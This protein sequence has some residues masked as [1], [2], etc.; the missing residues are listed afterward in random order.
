MASVKFSI[1]SNK[2]T[3]HLPNY[4]TKI[5]KNWNQIPLIDFVSTFLSDIKINGS[6][7]SALQLLNQNLNQIDK[8]LDL[9]KKCN[10]RGELNQLI[11]QYEIKQDCHKFAIKYLQS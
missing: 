8:D 10:I 5:S 9:F 4:E 3:N 6:K 7:Y 2:P 11:F 1:V